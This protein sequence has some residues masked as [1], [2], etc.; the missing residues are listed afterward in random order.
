MSIPTSGNPAPR[1]LPTAAHPNFARTSW[2][3]SFANEPLGPGCGYQRLGRSSSELEGF[4]Q[5]LYR[6]SM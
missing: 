6:S 4:L 3:A 2:K 1:L 5:S